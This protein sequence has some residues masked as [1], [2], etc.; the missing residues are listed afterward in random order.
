VLVENKTSK[1]YQFMI[2]VMI[3]HI[4]ICFKYGLTLV[5]NDK[6]AWIAE[7]EASKVLR[8]E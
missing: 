4:L 2:I 7:E 8:Q 1:F 6:P 3:E 5:I